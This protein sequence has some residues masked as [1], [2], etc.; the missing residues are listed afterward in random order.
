MKMRKLIALIS[1]AL[2]LCA[3]IPMGAMTVSAADA[4][5]FDD[6]SDGNTDGW[7]CSETIV[8]EDGA[9]KWTTASWQNLYYNIKVAAN[10]DYVLTFKMKATKARTVEFK[11]LNGSWGSSGITSYPSTSATE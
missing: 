1:A 5:L 9:M 8:V 4:V 6:F 10:T 7:N 11:F 3:I 2:M